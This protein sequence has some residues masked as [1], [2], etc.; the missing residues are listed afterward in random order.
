MGQKLTLTRASCLA[1]SVTVLCSAWVLCLSRPLRASLIASLEVADE[2]CDAVFTLGFRALEKS[3]RG[4]IE[5][6]I[7]CFWDVCEELLYINAA[8]R[9]EEGYGGACSPFELE[10][11]W[12]ASRLSR[13]NNC[14]IQSKSVFLAFLGQLGVNGYFWGHL[15]T[16]KDLSWGQLGV[17]YIF[18]GIRVELIYGYCFYANNNVNNNIIN[19]VTCVFYRNYCV[20]LCE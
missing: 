20:N 14:K 13:F 5:G 2:K 4:T 1:N 15:G 11:I 7:F 10:E 16:I 17:K 12:F 3:A 19:I 8:S 6:R 9:H 18:Y